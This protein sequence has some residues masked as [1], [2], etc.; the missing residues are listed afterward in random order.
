VRQRARTLPSI[1]EQR[2]DPD[3]L[4]A[5]VQGEDARARRGCLKLFLGLTASIGKRCMVL[6]TALVE[7]VAS[8]L[9]RASLGDRAAAI[10]DL[11]HRLPPEL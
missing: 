9:T 3:A 6:E 5:R 2:P 11:A 10:E 8:T 4:L 7:A 1:P